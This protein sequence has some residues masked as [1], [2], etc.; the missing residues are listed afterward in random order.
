MTLLRRKESC[1]LGAKLKGNFLTLW[2]LRKLTSPIGGCSAHSGPQQAE[3][4]ALVT[5]QGLSTA[6][7]STYD[8]PLVL[9]APHFLLWE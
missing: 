8:Q 1:P 2:S 3:A 4:M 6:V 7:F 5:R 9:W